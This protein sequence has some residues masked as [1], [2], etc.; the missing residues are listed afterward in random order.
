M[1]LE[2][3][4]DF[5]RAKYPGLRLWPLQTG[6]MF[7][8]SYPLF[9]KRLSG[10]KPKDYYTIMADNV[11]LKMENVI[12][13]F[14]PPNCVPLFESDPIKVKHTAFA[15]HGDTEQ[16][17]FEGCCRDFS[18]AVDALKGNEPLEQL[19]LFYYCKSSSTFEIMDND[20]LN[21]KVGWFNAGLVL[22]VDQ[23]V[24]PNHITEDILDENILK[25]GVCFYRDIYK[26][27]VT[28]YR[29]AAYARVKPSLEQEYKRKT[30]EF[31]PGPL[32]RAMER[33]T[34]WGWIKSK[35]IPPK[36]K[37]DGWL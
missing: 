12:H 14:R 20:Y 6:E 4:L 22:E 30:N 11:I 7:C 28:T 36:V 32:E 3:M 10:D 16:K 13:V 19:T 35:I 25:E 18:D 17:A 37:K 33:R 34:F 5:I 2:D 23:G 8:P 15:S 21:N 24:M 1:N 27:P 26:F 29:Q 31:G 9:A